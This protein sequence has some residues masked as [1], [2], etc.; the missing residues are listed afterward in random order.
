ML[1]VGLNIGAHFGRIRGVSIGHA[2]VAV[3]V[4]LPLICC[5][6]ARLDMW[7]RQLLFFTIAPR[8]AS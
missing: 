4:V 5:L 2:V 1:I 8:E 7:R 6:L 3:A